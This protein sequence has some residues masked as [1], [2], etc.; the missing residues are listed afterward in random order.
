MLQ[1]LLDEA[2]VLKEPA[3][4]AEGVAIRL[5]DRRARRRANVAQEQR[6]ADVAG[7]VPQVAVAP[8]RQRVAVEARPFAVVV[9]V[10]PAEAEAIGVRVAAGEAVVSA[11]LDK[12]VRR[13]VQ[14]RAWADRVAEIRDPATHVS[15]D[16]GRARQ[17][18][19]SPSLQERGSIACRSHR[20]A[21]SQ[22]HRHD[23]RRRRRSTDPTRATSVVLVHSARAQQREAE[24]GDALQ[25][26]VK[27][28]LVADKADQHRFP[29]ARVRVM[30]ANAGPTRRRS[31][32]PG[33]T[34]HSLPPLR[35]GAGGAVQGVTR[36]GPG[37]RHCGGPR[38]SRLRHCG[39]RIAPHRPAN[40]AASPGLR[41]CAQPFARCDPW[42]RRVSNL[43]PLA[44]EA[45]A[46]PLSYAPS[47]ASSLARPLRRGQLTGSAS[48][49]PG[50][51][52]PCPSS[53]AGCCQARSRRRPPS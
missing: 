12:P 36:L 35:S 43:R 11:L 3:A 25:N 51:S 52:S 29:W 8:G 16:P 28:G 9:C 19:R 41:G 46:L 6:R 15:P 23:R 33:C 17:A 22:P 20:S 24:V 30:P 37:V 21:A 5:L 27:L 32:R 39:A 1:V 53:R 7:E 2:V 10:V 45:S 4:V 42:A 26:P 44:C 18:H 13:V 47:G 40:R 38:A 34:S 50:R 49:P 14:Q 48:R 31:T